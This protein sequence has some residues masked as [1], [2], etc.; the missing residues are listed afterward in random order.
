VKRSVA[1]ALRFVPE[2]RKKDV[3]KAAGIENFDESDD[4]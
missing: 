3:K 4:E 2:A 1:D